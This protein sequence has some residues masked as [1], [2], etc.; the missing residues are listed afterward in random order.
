MI[1]FSSRISPKFEGIWPRPSHPLSFN[2]SWRGLHVNLE[3]RVLRGEVCLAGQPGGLGGRAEIVTSFGRF[4]L[5]N[6][7]LDPRFTALI[8]FPVC[9]LGL[10]SSITHPWGWEWE[11]PRGSES[12]TLFSSTLCGVLGLCE[13]ERP[14]CDSKRCCRTSLQW[15][16]SPP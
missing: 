1:L 12:R 8:G 7:L 14:S 13:E 11:I 5:R 9:V 6:V 4:F 2:S 15:G 16:L 3:V 10:S